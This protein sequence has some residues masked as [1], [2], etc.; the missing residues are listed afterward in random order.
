MLLDKQFP[1]RAESVALCS[2]M[3]VFAVVCGKLVTVYRINFAKVWS[4]TLPFNVVTVLWKVGGKILSAVMENG[5]VVH[6]DAENSCMLHTVHLKI[7]SKECFRYEKFAFADGAV[8]A[9]PC[10]LGRMPLLSN[11]PRMF[12]I[13]PNDVFDMTSKKLGTSKDVLISCTK[14][15][16]TLNVFGLFPINLK[17]NDPEMVSVSED[18]RSVL[19]ISN[20]VL[21]SIDTSPLEEYKSVI[22]NMA[23]NASTFDAYLYYVDQVLALIAKECDI[24]DQTIKTFTD[25]LQ[26]TVF[27]ESCE[28]AVEEMT[29]KMEKWSESVQ[30]SLKN[31][32]VL[33]R[34]YLEP[35]VERMAIMMNYFKDV[36]VCKEEYEQMKRMI[37]EF[38]EMSGQFD[39]GINEL[40]EEF[41]KFSEWIR[42]CKCVIEVLDNESEVNEENVSDLEYEKIFRFLQKKRLF[43][44]TVV[45]EMMRDE[46]ADGFKQRIEIIRFKANKLLEKRMDL[47][48]DSLCSEVVGRIGSVEGGWKMYQHLNKFLL[49]GLMNEELALIKVGDRGNIS[50]LKLRSENRLID[51]ELYGDEE[52]VV[53]FPNEFSVLNFSEYLWN[54]CFWDSNLDLVEIIKDVE[55]QKCEIE[56][57]KQLWTRGNISSFSVVKGRQLGLF[58]YQDCQQ[59]K[60]FDL[61]DRFTVICRD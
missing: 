4:V 10:S 37:T 14:D 29:A 30:S 41:V 32:Q 28:D 8:S 43:G 51:C 11:L 17:A 38:Y 2:T 56:N 54:E 16:I 50:V 44:N 58:V 1:V 59:F 12:V 7:E 52:V 25:S 15:S 49:M 35:V 19:Y 46:N 39:D 18:F 27:E 6:L 24:L 22:S 48:Y 55:S 47:I 9:V 60:L 61:G 45:N 40:S 33:T 21:Y 31:M 42:M 57:G 36:V 26:E 34:V 5:R 13:K 3:D 20:G 53:L 23:I